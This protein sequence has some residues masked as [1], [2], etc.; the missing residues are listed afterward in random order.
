MKHLKTYESIDNKLNIGDYVVVHYEKTTDFGGGKTT[1]A[2]IID[3]L[4]NNIAQIS[5]FDRADK[6]YIV[7]NYE[8]KPD[9]SILIYFEHINNFYKKI[10]NKNFIIAVGKDKEEL[11]SVL[12]GRNYNL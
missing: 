5:S 4:N 11:E 1:D 2:I 6:N 8:T 10:I 12:V 9:K 7:V 3:Y